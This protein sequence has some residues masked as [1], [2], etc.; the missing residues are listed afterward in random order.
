MQLLYTQPDKMDPAS[1]ISDLVQRHT[2]SRRLRSPSHRL[3]VVPQTRL[4]SLKDQLFQAVAP[5]I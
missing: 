4:K 5:G 1:Y 3:V 2:P